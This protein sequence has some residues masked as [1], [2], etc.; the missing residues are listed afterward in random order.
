M[1]VISSCN[2][3]ISDSGAMKFQGLFQVVLVTTESINVSLQAGKT[4]LST[5]SVTLIFAFSPT[6]IN[7][8]DDSY[9]FTVLIVV[10]KVLLFFSTTER[11]IKRPPYC[12]VPTSSGNWTVLNSSKYVGK[13]RRA[14]HVVLYS[15]LTQ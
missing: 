15:E 14:N 10:V 13:I 3:I 1:L 8:D 7:K 6:P 11:G 9:S 2:L 5:V 12:A 4:S